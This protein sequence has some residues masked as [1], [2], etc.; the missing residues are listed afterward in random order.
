MFR[1]SFRQ[2][3]EDNNTA[4]AAG[5]Q[6]NN[7]K[8]IQGMGDNIGKA[9]TQGQ[10]AATA[11]ADATKQAATTIAT[12]AANSGGEG[13]E[14]LGTAVKGADAIQKAVGVKPGAP[15]KKMKKK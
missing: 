2:W 10:D 5:V 9:L 3:M 11:A 1:I 15:V 6:M 8:A 4:A 12:N 7:R 13:M 14:D